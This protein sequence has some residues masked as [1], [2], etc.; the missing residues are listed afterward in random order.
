MEYRVCSECGGDCTLS[1][2]KK[3]GVCSWC[4]SELFPKYLPN[5][6]LHAYWDLFLERKINEIR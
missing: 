1:F 3:I 2:S 5:S 6:Q 4:R